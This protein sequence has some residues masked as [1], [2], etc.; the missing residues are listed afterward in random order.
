MTYL[1]VPVAARN[2]E[3]AVEQIKAAKRAGAEALELR[4]DYLEGLKAKAVRELLSQAKKGRRP[5]PVIVTCRDRAEGGA[6]AY[7]DRL[8]VAVLIAALEA[9]AEFVDFEYGKFVSTDN[10]EKIKRALSQN[11][12]GRLILSAHSF[13]GPFEDI[14]KLW[15]HMQSIDPGAIP[16]LVYK[17]RHINEC[18][19]AFD[20]LHRTS[21]ERIVFC[22]GQAGLIS[23]IIAKK[24]GSLV[25]FASLD[26]ASGTAPGQLTIEQ[27][28]KLY[29]YGDIDSRTEF[30]GVIGSPVAHSAS[31]AV[32][33]ACF[34]AAK[35]NKLYLPLLVEGGADELARF[36]NRIE[37]RPWLGFRGFSVTIPHKANALE[38]VRSKFGRVEGPAERIG[39]VNT[40]V[41]TRDGSWRAC[42]TDCA[43]AI[44]AILSAMKIERAALKDV[45]V[46]VVG[47]GGVA[48]AVVAGLRDAGAK[49]KIYNRTLAKAKNL[50]AEFGCDYASLEAAANIEAEL[51][52][53]CT[54]VGMHPNVDASPV[55]AEALKRSM[56]VFD[57][58]YNPARTLLLQQAREKRAK[59]IDGIS[60]FI[61]QAAE[62]FRLFTGKKADKQFMR[63]KISAFLSNKN[64]ADASVTNVES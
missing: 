19:E 25:T 3:G 49:V 36:L 40:L 48:R 10:Q 39:A 22:M 34:A 9:G 43:G 26:E 13:G 1:T 54:S 4:V 8:R 60:M 11:V 7:P 16:K 52:I 15:R 5:L 6:R 56:V 14:K 41:L 35:L 61:N 63:R 31:P 58:V 27:L 33:N 23:R 62:Q 17:A 55:P 30:Y 51:L 32:H 64:R 50:A 12:R 28:R 46:A 57:T 47:A 38:Y 45:R 21:G 59:T 42:N 2:V 44:E 18:F 24:L 53:N 29:R 37:V 20:L